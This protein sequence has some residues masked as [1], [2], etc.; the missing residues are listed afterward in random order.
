VGKFI[1]LNKFSS[2][3]NEF[4]LIV[5]IIVNTRKKKKRNLGTGGPGVNEV[6]FHA[7]PHRN[8]YRT[9]GVDTGATDPRWR[10]DS[11]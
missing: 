2:I 11:M 10:A 9:L 7:R 5:F 3:S 4:Y 6:S 1:C 8:V